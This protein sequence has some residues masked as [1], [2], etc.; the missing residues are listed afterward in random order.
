MLEKSEDVTHSTM[1]ASSSAASDIS[2]KSAGSVNEYYV[3]SPRESCDDL[4]E[5]VRRD[6]PP[7]EALSRRGEHPEAAFVLRQ[8]LGDATALDRIHVLNEVHDLALGP[9]VQH[10]SHVAEVVVGVNEDS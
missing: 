6:R 4:T 8:V 7:Q 3:E 5:A 1:F 2:L 10:R 9:D